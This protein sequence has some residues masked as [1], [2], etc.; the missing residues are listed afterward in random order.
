MF[1]TACH[2][3]QFW[4]RWIQSTHSSYLCLIWFNIILQPTNWSFNTYLSLKFSKVLYT[5]CT[6]PMHSTWSTH[7]ILPNLV[8]LILNDSD[9]EAPHDTVINM[10]LSLLPFLGLHYLLSTLFS[11]TTNLDSSFV[12]WH[13]ANW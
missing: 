11:N 13:I 3:A 9:H 2:Q 4:A 12:K 10:L 7:V 1:T 8:I 6:F 5:C